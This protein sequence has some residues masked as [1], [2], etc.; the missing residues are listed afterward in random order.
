MGE[1]RRRQGRDPTAW[2]RAALTREASVDTRAHK[3]RYGVADLRTRWLAEATDVGWTSE[4][5][6]DVIHAGVARTDPGSATTVILHR[7][8]C[9]VG[10]RV[11]MEPRRRP[12]GDLRP[13]AARVPPIGRPW[14]RFGSKDP[15]VATG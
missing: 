13:P 2:E 9:A 7:G 4:Q 5:L 14:R 11:D 15:R 6:T 8:R 1:F 10:D 12:A 3:S